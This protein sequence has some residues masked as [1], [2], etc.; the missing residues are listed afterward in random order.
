MPRATLPVDDA[1]LDSAEC[2]A[3]VKKHETAWW[4]LV[5]EYPWMERYCVRTGR[6]TY[7][8]QSGV[9]RLL[10]TMAGGGRKLNERV[11]RMRAARQSKRA[12]VSA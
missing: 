2:A 11:E 9:V 10:H 6:N 1:L 4:S 12:Q 3:R 7:W 8:L 5:R